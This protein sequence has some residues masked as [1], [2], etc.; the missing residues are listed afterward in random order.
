MSVLSREWASAGNL[1]QV[2]RIAHACR[3]DICK[4]RAFSDTTAQD[5][6]IA[7]VDTQLSRHQ[8]ALP[9]WAACARECGG[10]LVT[11]KILPRE[12]QKAVRSLRR[13]AARAMTAPTST[14][15][16][17]RSFAWRRTIVV[18][19]FTPD[20]LP[21]GRDIGET[22]PEVGSRVPKSQ[23][24]ERCI[25]QLRHEAGAQ[26]WRFECAHAAVVFRVA[27]LEEAAKIE[28]IGRA[29]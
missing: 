19:V 29:S 20:C 23:R 12:V 9:A 16:N 27:V 25:G 26:Q 6:S 17:S 10:R 4:S 5:T 24:P 28:E 14:C 22:R 15:A 18:P 3:L 13:R 8:V 2:S 21:C 1:G 7:L 11:R